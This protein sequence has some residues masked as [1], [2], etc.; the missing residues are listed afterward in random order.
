MN[1]VSVPPLI[2]QP[3]P[4][5]EDECGGFHPVIHIKTIQLSTSSLFERCHELYTLDHGNPITISKNSSQIIE[6]P[7]LFITALP[8]LSIVTADSFLYR[9]NL[10]YNVTI[11]PTNDSYPYV[12]ISNYTYQPITL[13]RLSV[14]CQI[15]LARNPT[16]FRTKS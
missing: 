3:R 12:T 9:Y 1:L 14:S 6:F 15:I 2:V 11:I 10:F 4:K 5:D 7:I 13:N 8:A 16:L